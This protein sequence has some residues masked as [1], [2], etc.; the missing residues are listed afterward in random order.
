VKIKNIRDKKRMNSKELEQKLNTKILGKRVDY[1]ESIDSTHLEAKRRDD[2]QIEDGLIIFA[3]SQ[4]GGIGTHSRKWYTGNDENLSF[5]LILLP[6]CNLL[7]IENLTVNLAKCI[8][9]AIKELYEIETTIK[10]PNDVYLNQ[11]KIAG[12]ITESTTK[13]D[14]VKKIYIGIGINVNQSYFPGTLK[15]KAT[16]LKNE[17][18]N[19]I[20]R[21]ELFAKIIENIEEEYFKIL[22]KVNQ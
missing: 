22:G 3:D 8:V 17:L 12:I 16:S 21:I 6:N 18:G 2:S 14:I 5:N 4:T 15:E 7:K 9:L 10:E 20:D 1:Y 13:G 19:D 11:K